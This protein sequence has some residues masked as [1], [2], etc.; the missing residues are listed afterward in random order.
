[1]SHELTRAYAAR[2]TEIRSQM[3]SAPDGRP[4]MRPDARA[5]VAAQLAPIAALAP[6][7]ADRLETIAARRLEFLASKLPK[8]PD[9][10]G[11][12]FGPD[13]WRPSEMEMRTFAR[14]AAAVE[15][16]HAIVE[17]LASGTVTP[18]D[19]EAMRE[20]YPEIHADITRQI[21]EKLSTLQKQ[22]PYQ[23]RIALSLFSGVAVDPAMDPRIL[24]QLQALH[25]A[26]EGSEQG[27]TAPTAQPQ[28]GSVRSADKYTPAQQRQMGA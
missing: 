6:V 28:F 19:A 13:M 3:G 23:R 14:Y 12:S 7:L 15:D 4:V 27:T 1:M 18:E 17:R 9:V 26:E 11:M 8:R 2:A 21:V 10:G 25:V 24:N 16:P 20:V 22:L 5:K